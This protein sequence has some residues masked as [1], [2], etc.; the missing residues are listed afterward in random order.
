MF[1][2]YLIAQA[3]RIGKLF[4]AVLAVTAALSCGLALLYTALIRADAA[5]GKRQ[6]VE[7]G[8]VGSTEG[9]YLGFGIQA[10]QSLDSSRFA[11]TFREMESEETA[12]NALE[13][14]EL[15]AYVLI[16]EDFVENLV[17]GVNTPATYVTSAGAGGIG[18]MVMGELVETIS[19]L[20]TESQNAVYSTQKILREQGRMDIYREAEEQLCL[21]LLALILGRESVCDLELSGVSC[22]L[23]VMEYYSCGIAILFLLLWGIA[24]APFMAGRN[25]AVSRLLYAR[26]LSAGGQVLAEYVSW[27]VLSAVC[28]LGIAALFPLQIRGWSLGMLPVVMV[29]AAMQFCIY[30]WV[31]G[32]VA[33]VLIQFLA[34]TVLGYLSGCFYPIT[35]F[36]AEIQ[37]LAPYLPTGAAMGYS[38]KLITGQAFGRELAVLG[39]Y[40]AGGFLLAVLRRKHRLVKG[41]EYGI[42]F[43]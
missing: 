8:L 40:G 13:R 23:S 7:V 16:P 32:P 31:S 3:K 26:G 4:P 19:I 37:V 21:R 5:Q 6:P 10:L 17:K 29:F 11:I 39:I 33:G 34:A 36:P 12:E 38:G 42:S 9:S 35:F 41:A 27:L 14:G 24:A 30:E 22:G 18:S 43:V 28:F 15:S 2:V 25:A 1:Q 20:I